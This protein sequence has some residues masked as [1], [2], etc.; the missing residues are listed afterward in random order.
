M[1]DELVVKGQQ[2]MDVFKEIAGARSSKYNPRIKLIGKGSNLVG[3][4][5]IKAGDYV[6]ISSKESRVHLGNSTDCVV[7]AWRPTALEI[8]DEIITCHDIETDLFKSIQEKSEIADSGCMFGPEFLLYIKDLGGFANYLCSTKTERNESSE[9]GAL[10]GKPATLKSHFIDPVKS[11]HS[12][13]GPKFSAC[14]TPFDLPSKE[15]M[16]E[17]RTRFLNPPKE[18]RVESDAPTPRAR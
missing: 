4:D 1:A 18:E 14:S 15:I 13:W 2:S 12:W 8:G 17:Q 6:A 16:D 9:L 7:L 3:I 10:V 5:S 11:K